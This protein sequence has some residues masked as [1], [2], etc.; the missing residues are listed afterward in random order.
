MK[1]LNIIYNWLLLLCVIETDSK[2]YG[3]CFITGRVVLFPIG[4]I[5]LII[6]FSVIKILMVDA[7]ILSLKM[8]SIQPLLMPFLGSIII[9]WGQ[10]ENIEVLRKYNELRL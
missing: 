10:K 3:K 9:L 7:F 8:H 5:M 4:R 2:L 6:G 1:I